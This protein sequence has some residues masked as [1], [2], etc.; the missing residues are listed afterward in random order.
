VTTREDTERYLR[1][2]LAREGVEAPEHEIAEMIDFLDRPSA[3]GRMRLLRRMKDE[4]V[5]AHRGGD[6]GNAPARPPVAPEGKP[7]D[8][9]HSP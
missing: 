2:L 6:P 5:K 3:S 9:R 4:L 7:P 1:R 8:P